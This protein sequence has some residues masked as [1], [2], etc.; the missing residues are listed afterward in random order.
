MKALLIRWAFAASLIIVT[1][2]VYYPGLSGGFFFDDGP[3][4]VDNQTLEVFDGTFPSL[5]AA[6]SGGVSSPLGRPLSMASFALNYHFL[7]DDPYYFK[8]VNLLIH[9]TNG[10]LVFI[11]V[12]QLWIRLVSVNNAFYAP[13]WVTAVWLLHPINLSPVLFVVQRMTSLAAMFT[14]AALCLYLYGRQQAGRLGWLAIA[15]SVC[16]FW[17]IGILFKETALLLPLFILI[18]EWQV[19]GRLQTINPKTVWILMCVIAIAVALILFSKWD[20]I[21]GGYGMRPFGISERLL[22]ES[23]VLWFYLLQLFAPWPNYFGMYHDDFLISHGLLSPASTLLAI[24]GWLLLAFIV[25]FYG[26]R[27]PLFA[28]AVAWYL[29]AHAL[30]STFLPLEMVYEHRNYLATLGILLWVAS[31]LFSSEAHWRYKFPKL[32]IAMSFFFFCAMVTVLRAD[33]WGNNYRRTQLEASTHPNSARANNEAAF[34]LMKSTFLSGGGNSFAFQA[35]SYHYKRAAKLDH[36]DKTALISLL[37]MR[38]M[39]GYQ[40]DYNLQIMLRERFANANISPGDRGMVQS[41][42]GLLIENRLCMND[43]DVNLLLDAGLSNPSAR[44]TI[45]GMIYTVG[46]DYAVAKL[47]DMEEGLRYARSAV[48]NSPGNVTFRVNLVRLLLTM[49]DIEQAKKEYSILAEMQTPVSARAEIA[50]LSHLLD[51]VE[52]NE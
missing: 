50:Q 38:C 42:S 46:M 4:I 43:D 13:F 19:L 20:V 41:L 23:R 25:I 39:T 16:L 8:L 29:A 5:I 33:Q 28:F 40:M 1:T 2:W 12:R 32:V 34:E 35:A 51:K 49:K 45:R 22:T 27:F 10:I 11:L 3:N 47:G 48:N 21:S 31:L 24:M 17:P 14:L 26:G 36:N 15:V 6:S 7:G 44:G 9:L 37:Y 52:T 18:L 30:E